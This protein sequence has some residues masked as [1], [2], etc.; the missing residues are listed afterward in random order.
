METDTNVHGKSRWREKNMECETKKK[1]NPFEVKDVLTRTCACAG[2]LW[3]AWEK[4]KLKVTERATSTC[5]QSPAAVAPA[6][7][8]LS[9]CCCNINQSTTEPNCKFTRAPCQ[10]SGLI[11]PTPLEKFLK[12]GKSGVNWEAGR[13]KGEGGGGIGDGRWIGRRGRQW[14]R[15]QGFKGVF[16]K[17]AI[18]YCCPL[19]SPYYQ[20]TS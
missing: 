20:N 16:K 7:V 12:K 18:W 13:V 1:R 14:A 17:K 9:C 4:K 8:F 10:H 3:C 2:W 15:Q 6:C 11:T 19:L 5:S